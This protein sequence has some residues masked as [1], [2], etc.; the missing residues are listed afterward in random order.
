MIPGGNFTTIP[1]VTALQPPYDLPYDPVS[2]IVP[3]GIAL[4]DPSEGRL[5]QNWEISYDG[6][7]INIK[8][9]LSSVVF[10]LPMPGVLTV[11]LAFDNNMGLAFAWQ[12]L[13][14]SN[15]YYFDTDLSAYTTKIFPGTTSC[16]VCVDE[17]RDYYNADSD[18]MIGYT[19]SNTLYYRQQRDK[20]NIEYTVGATNRT[21]RKMAPSLGNRLQFELR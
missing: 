20:Y 17:P 9:V 2:Q 18:V 5:Y 19:R 21:L 7:N 4:S 15:L 16:R 14:G 10:T 12:T 3:G 13:A 11:S 8:P 1:V 6:A